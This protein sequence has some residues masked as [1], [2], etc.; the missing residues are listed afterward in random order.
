[1]PLYMSQFTYTPEAW[2]AL[3]RDPQDR[4]AAVGGLME[5]MGGRLVAFYHS[6]GEYDGVIISESPDDTSAAAGVLAGISAGH[7]KSIKTTTLLSVEDAMEAMRR[8]G[9]VTFQRPGQ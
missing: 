7:V 6:F 8:A 1:M 2:A 3:T 5:S 9:E 4:S